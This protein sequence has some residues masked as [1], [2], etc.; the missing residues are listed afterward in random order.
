MKRLTLKAEVQCKREELEGAV[1]PIMRKLYRTPSRGRQLD[2]HGG[3]RKCENERSGHW[4]A[5]EQ[6]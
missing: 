3:A 1:R 2:T 6:A 5:N 4:E